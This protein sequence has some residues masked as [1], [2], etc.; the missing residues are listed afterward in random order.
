M[1]GFKKIIRIFTGFFFIGSV[2]FVWARF[3][4]PNLLKTETISLSLDNFPK[5]GI[6]A[7]HITDL[8]LRGPREIDRKVI[9][10]IREID[11]DLIFI[12]GDIIDW[13]TTDFDYC[14]D[15]FDR[16]LATEDKIYVIWGNHEHRN[17]NF[18]KLEEI[19]SE[20]NIRVLVNEA[21]EIF[22]GNESFYLVGL[23]DPHLGFDDM[24]KAS[25]GL[26]QGKAII[27]LAHSPEIFRK[28]KNSGADL[29]LAGHTHGCQIN[30]PIICNW[31][32]PLNYDKQFKQGLFE[33]EGTYLY[34]NRGIGETFLPFRFNAVPEITLIEIHS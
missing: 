3:V 22:V 18:Y 30:L 34:V 9:D 31:F 16:L 33:K 1:R 5:N 10:K 32:V 2:L 24:E 29:V 13:Q 14:A 11:P 28:I 17:P 6:R 8:H 26:E 23:D 12:T 15:F 4:E 20:R 19:L 7:V 25:Q 21:R 27:V